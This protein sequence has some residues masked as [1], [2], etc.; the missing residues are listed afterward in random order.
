MDEKKVVVAL[1]GNAII[2][3]GQKGSVYEQFANTREALNNIF[4]LIQEGHKIVI[5]HGNGPQVGNILLRVE[6][7]KDIAY[8]L[9]LG[10]CVAQ[11]QGEMGY[12]IVQ[13]LQN[14]LIREG[15]ERNAICILTQVVVDKNDPSMKNPTK[16]IGKFYTEEEAK[17]KIEKFKWDMV[18]DA[19]RGWRRVVPSPKPISIVESES[20]KKSFYSGDIVIACGGGG[21]PVYVEGEGTYEGVDAVV[22]KD[23]AS[24]VLANEIGADELI[25]LT[26][27]EFVYLN[28]GMENETILKEVSLKEIKKYYE[29]GHFPPGNMGPKIEAVINFL[30]RGGKKAIITS[31]EKAYDA[32]KGKTGTHIFP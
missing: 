7:S 10:V 8:E 18:E 23:L 25:I 16:P 14:K 19:G 11:S 17:E 31:T 32:L 3:K 6:A 30:E 12:M 21:I 1:G 20:I 28:F 26:G 27:V 9:P 5:T 4:G 22:D 24:S 29:E 2:K 15:I 13:S